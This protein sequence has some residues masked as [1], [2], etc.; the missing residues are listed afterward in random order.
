MIRNLIPL[1]IGAVVGAAATVWYLGWLAD[2]PQ[3]G[4]SLPAVFDSVARLAGSGSRAPTQE[5]VSVAERLGV[6]RAAQTETDVAALR[7]QLGELAAQEPSFARDVAVDAA[8]ARMSEL[9]PAEAAKA[10]VSLALEPRFI[11]AAFLAF[12]ESAPEAALAGLAGIGNASVR[13][14]V[15]LSLLSVFGDEAS[16]LERIASALPVADR[17]LLTSDWLALRVEYDPYGAF[18]AATSLGNARLEQ[19]A[20]GAI[21]AAWAELDPVG[22]LAASEQLAEPLAAPFRRAVFASWARLDA[23]AFADYIDSLTRVPAEITAGLQFLIVSDPERAL[24]VAEGIPG[25]TGEGMRLSALSALA[26]FDPAAAQLRLAT[27]PAGQERDRLTQAI[28]SAMARQDPDA[29]LVWAEGL[30]PPSP[31]ALRS[32][33]LTIAQSDV[34]AAIRLLD[35]PTLRGESSLILSMTASL[36]ARDPEQAEHVATLLLERDNLQSKAALQNLVSNWMQQDAEAALEWVLANDEAVDATMLRSAAQNLARQDPMGAAAIVNRL[37]EQHR[38][39]WVIQ[40]AGQ[41]ALADSTAAMTWLS[42]YQGQDFYEQALREAVMGTAQSE[43]R[44]AADLLLQAGS[45]IQRGA[46]SSVASSYARTEPRA[47]ATWASNLADPVARSAAIVSAVGVWASTDQQGARNWTM[48]LRSGETR[49]QALSNLVQ[50]SA[51]GGDFDTDLL[52]AFSSDDA[53]QQA[54]VSA[55]SMLSQTNPAQA[56]ELL[57]KEVTDTNQRQQLRTM[58][59]RNSPPASG[60]FFTRF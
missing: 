59:E 54:L 3:S 11:A 9:A 4:G 7:L 18:R 60:A 21:A 45:E 1:L 12:A 25:T 23:A 56:E 30:D 6:Y 17:E 44:V 5:P 15:A 51:S 26:E 14:D 53:R 24:R 46:A 41:Y 10:A 29:A 19:Q 42:Q 27:L 2:D 34:D 32:V 50:R 38:A 49:D 48:S 37:P 16:G 33:A 57:D 39:A 47:A 40:V 55:I 43:P 31:D 35:R 28:A 13:R 22:A 8:L 52:R 20:L 58:L 36:A